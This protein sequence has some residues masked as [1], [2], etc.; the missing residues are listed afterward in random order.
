M[1][2]L[3][4]SQLASVA[5]GLYGAWAAAHLPKLPPTNGPGPKFTTPL[6][7]KTWETYLRSKQRV[8]K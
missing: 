8:A 6:F 7:Q 4:P 3:S 1:R 5:G 2:T